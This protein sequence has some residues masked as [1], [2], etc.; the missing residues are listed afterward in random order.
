MLLY[1]RRLLLVPLC[2]CVAGGYRRGKRRQGRNRLEC[3]L[4]GSMVLRAGNK[5]ETEGITLPEQVD[6]LLVLTE[7]CS[8]P[9]S[10]RSVYWNMRGS[11][12]F[13]D[14]YCCGCAFA[15]STAYTRRPISLGSL[16]WTLRI[17]AVSIR[18]SLQELRTGQALIPYIGVLALAVATHCV[19][20]VPV[21]QCQRQLLC[22]CSQLHQ[23]LFVASSETKA[24]NVSCF[25]KTRLRL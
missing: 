21:P 4:E 24:L 17:G 8:F 7:V 5:I 3:L 23:G 9:W 11:T 6:R 13:L 16:N 12:A 18:A 15:N 2:L 10:S 1:V 19:A 20:E 14:G 25:T 22:L